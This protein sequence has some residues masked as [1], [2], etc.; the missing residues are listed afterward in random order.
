M[1]HM[2]HKFNVD[3][4]KIAIHFD[5]VYIHAAPCIVTSWFYEKIYDLKS[6]LYIRTSWGGSYTT[7]TYVITYVGLGM[8]QNVLYF[9]I[10]FDIVGM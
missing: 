1:S 10:M 5:E 8:H 7:I 9:L 6:S 4:Q 2:I 3:H